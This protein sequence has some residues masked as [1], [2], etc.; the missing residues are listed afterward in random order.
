M[1]VPTVT[2]DD[3]T[4]TTSAEWVV[5]DVREPQEWAGGH[6]EG[7]L[8]IPL[9]DLPARIDELDPQSRT[10]VVCHA[11]GRSSRATVWLYQQG[12]DVVNLA[13]GMEAWEGAER[14]VVVP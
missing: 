7:A 3:V 2:V 4:T 11:G 6:I 10:V 1:D 12:H 9:G 5:L 8:H 13:G 14:P